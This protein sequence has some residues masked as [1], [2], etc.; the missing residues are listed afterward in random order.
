MGLRVRDFLRE[1]KINKRY[2]VIATYKSSQL[3]IGDHKIV[4]EEEF[5]ACLESPDYP[6]YVCT[7][8]P[9]YT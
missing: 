7:Y 2:Q 9:Q 6:L 5:V 3:P 8:E 4:D 1:T